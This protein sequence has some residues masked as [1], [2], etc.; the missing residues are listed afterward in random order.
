M[1]HPKTRTEA[2]LAGATHYFTGEPCIRGH[3]AL[4]KVK[5]S[6]VDC[7][8]EDWAID[9]ARRKELPKTEAAKAAGRRYYEKNKNMVL[10]RAAARPLAEQRRLRTEYKNRNL[11]TVRADTSVRR[12]RHREATPAWITKDERLKM[13]ELYV[14]ARKLT[15]LAGEPYVVDHIVPL[16]S[17]V[18]CGLHVPWNLRVITRDENARKSNKLLAPTP[19]P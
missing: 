9:N 10:A 8:R 19:N 6:C 12:R 16:I 3:V 2:K 5:G 18:V 14:Q 4:R 13:R 7:V 17:D 15:E 1:D 11:D